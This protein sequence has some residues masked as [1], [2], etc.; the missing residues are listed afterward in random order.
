MKNC[1]LRIEKFLKACRKR[2]EENYLSSI[3]T[4]KLILVQKKG[5]FSQ[6]TERNLRKIQVKFKDNQ[7]TKVTKAIKF[8]KFKEI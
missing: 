5:W 7:S 1:N 6:L 3:Y 4:V 8:L 2:A